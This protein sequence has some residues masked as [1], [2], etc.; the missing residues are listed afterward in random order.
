MGLP[1]P[2]VRSPHDQDFTQM[3]STGFR[4]YRRG[5]PT[6]GPVVRGISGGVRSTAELRGGLSLALILA[7]PAL[8]AHPEGHVLPP[9]VRV[10]RD[11][12]VAAR[13]TEVAAR[14]RQP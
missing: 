2:R 13:G 1:D 12:P 3:P 9:G 6:P 8:R 11:I 14:H 5:R 7:E 10:I 4:R